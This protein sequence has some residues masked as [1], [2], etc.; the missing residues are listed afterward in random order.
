MNRRELILSSAATGLA[1]TALLMLLNEYAALGPS[2]L[3]AASVSGPLSILATV[4]TTLLTPVPGRTMLDV[5]REIRVPGGET[6]YDREARLARLR[7]RS[8][9]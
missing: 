4:T 3:I 5:V 9:A 8:Q 1:M 7:V 2:S 6:V